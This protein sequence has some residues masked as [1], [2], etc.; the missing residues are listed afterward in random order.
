[1]EKPEPFEPGRITEVNFGMQDVFH[2]FRRGHSIMVQVQS[3]WFPLVDRNPQ[4]F[5]NIPTARESDFQKAVQRVY[6]TQQAASSI[7]VLVLPA[8]PN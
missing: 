7:S 2:T 1:M 5:V 8:G 3:S 6:R 4:T